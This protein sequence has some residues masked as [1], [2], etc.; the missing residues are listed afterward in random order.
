[1][2]IS[3][4]LGVLLG[5]ATMLFILENTAPITVTFFSWQFGG[6]LSIVL[7]F[8]VLSGIVVTLL[9]VL[10]GSINSYFKYRVLRKENKKLA[11]E[12]HRQQELR[13][14][15]KDSHP[16]KENLSDIE[17]GAVIHPEKV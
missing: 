1:M 13:V 17:N 3:L 12:L 8:A 16:T 2:I 10:P 11:D 9:L 6:S 14:F 5:G 7:I 15:A 4:I